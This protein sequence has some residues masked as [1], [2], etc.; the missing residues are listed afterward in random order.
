MPLLT[1]QQRLQR[2]GDI[3]QRLVPA[4]HVFD[5]YGRGGHGEVEV[6]HR[7]VAGKVFDLE[8]DR[9]ELAA[10]GSRLQGRDVVGVVQ[11]DGD[12]EVL[13]AKAIVE[14]LA[15]DDKARAIGDVGF[16]ERRRQIR[17]DLERWR[18]TAFAA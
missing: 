4:A 6:D 12:V 18:R 11:L 1:G 9:D 7:R 13:R 5:E 14:N 16:I 17:I 15:V 3:E 8:A 10:V 2:G